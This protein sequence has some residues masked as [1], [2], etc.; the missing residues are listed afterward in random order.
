[1]HEYRTYTLTEHDFF[2]EVVCLFINL[3]SFNAATE[4]FLS[5]SA[6]NI[7]NIPNHTL[8]LHGRVVHVSF[9]IHEL[10]H[11]VVRNEWPSQ[12]QLAFSPASVEPNSIPDGVQLQSDA[13]ANMIVQLVGT[14]FLKYYERNAHRPKAA[15]P[16]GPKTWPET[17]RFAWLLRNAIAHGDKW[18]LGD[19]S[20]PPTTWNGI[21]VSPIDSGNSWFS[22]RDG[23][24]NPVPNVFAMSELNGHI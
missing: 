9:P 19:A 20:F 13:I 4:S 5:S 7:P 23:V 8:N 17:W 16:Q 18:A 1:M 2:D 3:A 15:Y 10:M 22:K 6:T 12:L 24:C 14:T 11:M 21:S